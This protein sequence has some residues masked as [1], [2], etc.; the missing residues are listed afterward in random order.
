MSPMARLANVPVV[1]T[2]H[3]LDWQRAKWGRAARWCL[4]LGELAAART[5]G[6]LVVVSK[7]LR[8]YFL[9]RYRVRA[10]YVP[11]GVVPIE[12]R[13][14]RRMLQ[15]G[16]KP[17]RYVLAAS[18]LVPE[19]GLH[20]LIEAFRRLDTPYQLVIAGGGLLEDGYEERLRRMAGPNV[21]FTGNAGGDLLAELYW[22]ATLFLLPSE[23]EGMSVALLEAMSCGLPVLVSDIVENVAVIGPNGFTFRSGDVADL[24]AKLEFL[25]AHPLLLSEAGRRLR[26]LSEQFRWPQIAIQLERVYLELLADRARR[27]GSPACRSTRCATPG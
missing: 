15:F 25:L 24:A 18:R 12:R 4:Q 23:L 1:V 7:P 14:P 9:A 21:I 10:T 6:R 20:Y 27:C 2:V 3:G 8:D 22:N 13:A 19:K 5:A 26:E 11:N 17:G 16:I